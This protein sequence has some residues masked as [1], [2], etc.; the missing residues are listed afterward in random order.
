ML[1][2]SKRAML[3]K[4]LTASFMLSAR[5]KTQ[6][7]FMKIKAAALRIIAGIIVR[8]FQKSRSNIMTVP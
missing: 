8:C 7:K 5:K 6:A 4:K 1:P 2:K 3:L